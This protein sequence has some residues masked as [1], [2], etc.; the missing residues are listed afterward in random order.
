M[1]EAT[2]IYFYHRRRYCLMYSPAKLSDRKGPQHQLLHSM[3]TCLQHFSQIGPLPI[4]VTPTKPMQRLF[5]RC[6][7]LGTEVAEFGAEPAIFL[8]FQKRKGCILMFRANN[9]SHYCTHQNIALFLYSEYCNKFKYC[10]L[11]HS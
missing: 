3:L 1:W 10:T 7:L 11:L 8:G 5:T 9:H 4:Q 2:S 6:P